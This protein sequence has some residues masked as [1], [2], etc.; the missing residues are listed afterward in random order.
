MRAMA[1]NGSPRKKWNTAQLLD[2]ALA[3]AA[4]A[5]AET[6]MV[7]LRDLDFTGCISC[8]SCKTIDGP[9]FGRCVLKDELSPA[10]ER[11]LETDV[12]LLGSP[13]YFHVQSGA[14]RCFL[15]R[16]MFPLLEY[17][18]E[19]S[20][21]YPGSLRVASFY[22]MNVTEERMDQTGFPAVRESTDDFL[23]RIF[24][25]AVSMASTDTLQ[26]NDY[27]K[28]ATYPTDPEHKRK[29]HQTVFAEE[30]ARALELGKRLVQEARGLEKTARA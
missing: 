20:S 6:E 25:N 22:T 17:V 21:L 9:S 4:Q 15:E 1:I 23:R 8:Y 11:I 16:L 5:G 12:L 3:G 18:R 2:H 13:V 7:H 28:Y 14:M 19:P 30:C 26:F 27:S 24:G 10:L 29:R